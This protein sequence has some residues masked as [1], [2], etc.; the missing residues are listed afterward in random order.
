MSVLAFYRNRTSNIVMNMNI[1]IKLYKMD[2]GKFI[3]S[4]SQAAEIIKLP[5]KDRYKLI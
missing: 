1:S 4:N 5:Q 2:L 3:L